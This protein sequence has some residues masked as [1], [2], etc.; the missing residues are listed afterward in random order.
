MK[1]EKW[2]FSA[3]KLSSQSARVFVVQLL[4]CREE[5]VVLKGTP[6]PNFSTVLVLNALIDDLSRQVD[7]DD[8]AVAVCAPELDHIVALATVRHGNPLAGTLSVHKVVA[9]VGASCFGSGRGAAIHAKRP[10]EGAV[11]AETL[12]GGILERGEVEQ[13]ILA[14]QRKDLV[15]RRIGVQDDLVG[16]G[17]WRGVDFESWGL[18]RLED[19]DQAVLDGQDLIVEGL[20]RGDDAQSVSVNVWRRNGASEASGGEEGSGECPLHGDYNGSEASWHSKVS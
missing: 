7:C 1:R 8:H 20:L 17:R 11:G 9:G 13:V 15:A 16:P 18:D 12:D 14:D 6:L 3:T 10:V 2:E 5:G 19:T 4:C